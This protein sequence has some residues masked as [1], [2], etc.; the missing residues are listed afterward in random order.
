M[1]KKFE[2]LAAQAEFP[3]VI[4]GDP[5]RGDFV[6]FQLGVVVPIP[7]EVKADV[8]TRGL[9][10]LGIVGIV[11]GQPRTALA[12]PLDDETISALAGAYVELVSARVR[13]A[14][15]PKPKDDFQNFAER[16]FQLPDQRGNA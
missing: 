13:D 1:D 2:T 16:L 7:E 8:I 11:G 3:T 5:K 14:F 12:M 10:F 9:G 15:A 4:W 6:L